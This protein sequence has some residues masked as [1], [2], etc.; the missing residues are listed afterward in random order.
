MLLFTAAV[1]L[2][3]GHVWYRIPAWIRRLLF[4][5]A[6][7]EVPATLSSPFTKLPQEVIEM[8]IAHLIYDTRSLLA[9]SLTCHSW[10]F[11]SVHHLHRTLVIRPCQWTDEPKLGWPKL[12]RNASELRF[13]PFVK[14]FQ[15]S[16]IDRRFPP[17]QLNPRILLQF[18]ALT[19]VRELEIDDLHIHDSLPDIRQYFGHLLPTVRSLTL[20]APEGSRRQIIFFIGLFQHLEDLTLLGDPRSRWKAQLADDLTLTPSFAPPLRGRL[21]IHDFKRAGLWED[22]IHLFGGIRF[23]YMNLFHVDETRLLLGACE[24]T[25]ETLRL[26]PKDPC[27]EQLHP[28]G[29]RTSTDNFTASPCNPGLGLFRNRSFRTFEIM[30]RWMAHGCSYVLQP[31]DSSFLTSV[32]STIT[33]PAFSEVVVFYRDW[34]FRGS[35]YHPSHADIYRKMS[36][37]EEAEE[38]LWHQRR[39]EVLRE[40]Y[41]VRQ[42]RL[43]LCVEVW[44]LVGEY[45][46]RALKRAIAVE[47]A[48]NRFDYLPSEPMVV[49]IPRG[50]MEG[51]GMRM[52]RM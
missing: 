17:G 18:S 4:P 12:P 45:A 46:M 32:L 24:E 23:R 9:C 3:F 43:V 52:G 21:V 40:M 8:I 29:A 20:R 2:F 16:R 36:S 42:F 15:L 34:D 28:K 11:A 49:Y 48:A 22:M 39:F 19:N 31:S 50:S 14:N 33:S 13:L 7:Q 10:Y 26:Y 6:S 38:A 51:E 27:G 25:L 1:G 37:A 5:W 44:D 47:K 35:K 30:A 41:A